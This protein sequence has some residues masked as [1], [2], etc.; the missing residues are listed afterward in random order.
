MYANGSLL[1]RIAGFF[2]NLKSFKFKLENLT[3]FT[4]FSRVQLV[5]EELVLC[6]PL[7]FECD[8]ILLIENNNNNNNNLK[9]VWS[10]EK[11][12]NNN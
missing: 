5:K 6:T 4:I 8:S 2:S 10:A 7:N 11:R 1:T 3:I 12:N 9:I